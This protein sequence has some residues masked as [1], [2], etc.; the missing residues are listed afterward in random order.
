M[1]VLEPSKKYAGWNDNIKTAVYAVN[2]NTGDTLDVG[3]NSAVADFREVFSA[4][5]SAPGQTVSCT[6]NATTGV[7]TVGTVNAG[8]VNGYLIVEGQ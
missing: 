4:R 7:V 1:A 6:W 3:V 5:F 2:A 8:P